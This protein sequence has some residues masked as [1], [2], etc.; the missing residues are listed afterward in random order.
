MHV[1]EYYTDA[2]VRDKDWIL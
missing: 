1:T 2:Q